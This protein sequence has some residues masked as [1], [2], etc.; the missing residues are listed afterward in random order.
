MT[1]QA[2]LS[3]RDANVLT[4]ALENTLLVAAKARSVNYELFF[5]VRALRDN[6]DSTL[7]EF[8]ELLRV[9]QT[10]PEL[11]FFNHAYQCAFGHRNKVDFYFLVG[12]LISRAQQVGAKQT[13]KDLARYLDVDT[14]KLI[15]IVTID[16]LKVNSK[17]KLGDYKLISW[18]DIK[19]TDTKFQM[20]ARGFFSGVSPDAAIIQQHEVPRTHLRLWEQHQEGFPK[21]LEPILDMLYCITAVVDVGIRIIY[22]WF[23]P[24]PWVPW[25]VRSN[26]F[27]ID[28]GTFS[29][30]IELSPEITPRLRKFLSQFQTLDENKKLRFRTPLDRLN[31][32]YLVGDNVGKAI[33]LGIALES[34]YAPMKLSEGIANAIRVRA[35]RF[36]GGS[37]GERQK[38]VEILKDVYDLRSLAIHT[39]RFDT[40]NK[41][42]DDTAVS[43][44]L[45]EG[46]RLVA[47]SLIKVIS[48]G[49]PKWEDFDI[50]SDSYKTTV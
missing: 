43:E 32:S 23:E 15:E 4:L 20:N 14:V 49:E 50:A 47:R 1:E 44:V 28:S 9:I 3:V 38:I 36:L 26:T 16:G 25:K 2:K 10:I 6:L 31:R 35:A 17:I 18:S 5:Q 11:E 40:K 39:G 21:S 33:E 12:W 19:E 42:R 13:I 34:L 29:S 8:R 48:N 45:K 22:Y 37:F 24:E 30:P 41:W 7:K 46:Q 27:E